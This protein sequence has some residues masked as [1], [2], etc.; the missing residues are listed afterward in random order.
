MALNGVWDAIALTIYDTLLRIWQRTELE[1]TKASQKPYPL[2]PP[3]VQV[4]HIK[5]FQKDAFPKMTSLELTEMQIPGKCDRSL[6]RRHG[7]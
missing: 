6:P 3:D 5:A 7:P 2:L 4:E 1:A